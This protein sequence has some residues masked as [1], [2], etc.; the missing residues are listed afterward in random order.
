M[1]TVRIRMYRL[2]MG[3]CFLLSFP[4]E[5]RPSHVLIDCGIMNGTDD[6]ASRLKQAAD[7]IVET[8]G[9]HLDVLVITQQ[10]WDHVAGFV[11]A[12]KIFNNLSIGE[13]WLAWT[14]DPTDVVA[15]KIRERSERAV[16]AL[17][18]AAEKV[19]A[20]DDDDAANRIHGL[21]SQFGNLDLVDGAAYQAMEWVK[22]R[23][24]ARVRYFQPNCDPVIVPGAQNVRVYV[25]GPPR[26]TKSVQSSNANSGSGQ[27]YGLANLDGADLG[28][29]SAAESLAGNTAADRQPFNEW[30]RVSDVEGRH[31][32]WL[33]ANYGFEPGDDLEWRRIETDW[34]GA[35]NQL[36]LQL[37]SHTNNTSLALAFEL[38]P[39]GRVLLFPGDAQFDNWQSWSS[40][41]WQIGKGDD[42]RNVTAA[43][44][45]ARTVLYK[46][47]HHGSHSGTPRKQGL[48]FLTSHE[49]VAMLT[50]DRKIARKLNWNMPFPDLLQRLQ[51]MTGGRILDSELGIPAS[52]PIGANRL[53]WAR[54]QDR[55]N[56]QPN[57]IDYHIDR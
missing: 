57:W 50:V 33:G 21:V 9:G 55:I 34:L 2:G 46:V 18:T 44:L 7:S 15:A 29:L 28:F 5:S 41:V 25:L 11:E 45:L 8:T 37:D 54:F 40:C 3:D 31:N 51:E 53:E 47:S 26:E 20:A 27:V 12:E 36:A 24:N 13:V 43:D 38:S 10:H 1:N 35:S 17:D 30:F 19:V 49:L 6:A 52:P 16:S 42:R 22:R 4:G 56:V 48:E 14:E 32:D 23:S 39:S